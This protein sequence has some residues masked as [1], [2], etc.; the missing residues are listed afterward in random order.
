MAF[1]FVQSKISAA[2]GTNPYT[3]AF[4]S[5]VT[6]G[7]TIIAVIHWAAATGSVTNATDNIN[8]GSYTAA[9][10]VN[11]GSTYS[12]QAYYFKNTLAGSLTVSFTM[13]TT[14]TAFIAIYEFS[15]HATAVDGYAA[16]NTN[17]AGPAT[18]GTITTTDPNDLLI[19]AVRCNS[20]VTYPTSWTHQNT[21]GFASAYF[22][23]G[24]SGPRQA[25]FSITGAQNWISFIL[26]LSPN[27]LT[28][29]ASFSFPWFVQEVI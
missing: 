26:A 14:E 13:S 1:S 5:P 21:G 19:A 18:G 8:S 25:N 20:V 6:A 16:N 11:Q 9:A 27:P 28:P 12:I 23:P 2:A 29:T 24:S 15:G 10:V 22:L 7:N 4:T 3:L 17:S